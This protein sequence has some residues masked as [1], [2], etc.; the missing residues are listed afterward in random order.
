MCLG[1]SRPEP[2]CLAKERGRLVELALCV[3]DVAQH[4]PNAPAVESE[5]DGF[6]E[7]GDCLVHFPLFR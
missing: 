2:Y 3:Q 7:R 4:D 6:A 5:F 1:G